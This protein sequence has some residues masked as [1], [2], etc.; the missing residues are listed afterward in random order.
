MAAGYLA[1]MTFWIYAIAKPQVGYGSDTAALATFAA[2]VVLHI[3]TAWWIGRW[4][5]VLLPP[6]VIL[7]AIPAGT[8][9][10]GEDPFPIWVAVTWIVAPAGAFLILVIVAIRRAAWP[11]AQ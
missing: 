4:W 2:L 3:V 1:A 9:V 8:P 10:K 11:L 5:A 6:L 7:L